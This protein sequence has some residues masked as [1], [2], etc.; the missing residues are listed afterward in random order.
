MIDK[1]YLKI[2]D[3]SGRLVISLPIQ[4]G[5]TLSAYEK[6][7]LTSAQELNLEYRQVPDCRNCQYSLDS[8]VCFTDCP[9]QE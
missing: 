5:Y 4:G 2:S 6:E 9:D 8:Q 1:L 7:L 3:K